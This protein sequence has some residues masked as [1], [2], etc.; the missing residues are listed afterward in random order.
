MGQEVFPQ[1]AA[2]FAQGKK[3]SANRRLRAHTLYLS[4]TTPIS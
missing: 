2:N 1:T 3:T 4:A